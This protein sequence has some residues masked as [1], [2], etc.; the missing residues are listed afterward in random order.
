MSATDD[1]WKSPE[2]DAA[3]PAESTA[4]PLGGSD[5]P[6]EVPKAVWADFTSH[7]VPYILANLGYMGIATVFTFAL[8]AIM[9]IG[10]APG[11]VTEDETILLVGLA[12]GFSVYMLGIFFLAFIAVPLWSASMLR[13]LDRQR[14]GECTIG[15][16][17]SFNDMKPRA[18][19]VIGTYA[20][21][22][23]LVFVGI[24]LFYIPGLIAMAVGTFALPIAVF[25][26]VGPM[27]AWKRAWHHASNHAAWHIGVFAL[28][29][30]AL[31]AL[32]L[33]LVGLLFIWPLM[34]AWQL[35]AY[36]LAFGEEGS[37]PIS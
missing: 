33:T 18:A 3:P 24:F 13:G 23:A 5:D 37:Q 26:D 12:A 31:I 25:E 30:M 7:P 32:E 36:R 10:V 1:V 15:F 22:Q 27:E 16:A 17:S 19:G 35:Y 29:F 14:R 20:L 28:L 9:G 11:I 6:T 8:L 4:T 21:T 2:A 34:C